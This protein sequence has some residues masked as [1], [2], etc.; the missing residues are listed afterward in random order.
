MKIGSN[1]EVPKGK[2]AAFGLNLSGR[3]SIFVDMKRVFSF[4]ALSVLLLPLPVMAQ[5]ETPVP[6]VTPPVNTA[7]IVAAREEAEERYKRMATDLQAVQSDN[8]ALHAKIAS[9]E[10]QI[11]NLRD[12]QAKPVDN[13]AVQDQLKLLAQKIEEVDK[14]R[15]EDK[16]TISDEIRKS[17]GK[18]Q[19]TLQDV[20]SL[21]TRESH[22][23]RD[24]HES[25]PKIASAVDSPAIENGYSYTI[26]S[27]DRLDL[28]VK[29]YNKDF[30][31][32]GL[33][34][35]TM[36]QAREANP[37]VNWNRL[38]VGQKIIIPR[39]DGG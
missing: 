8:E 15:L 6:T 26:A 35:I 34:P 17:V 36:K 25:R 22:D 3:D 4:I 39:P 38:L 23:S 21:P 32:K 12:A 20:P 28:I 33:K 24:T 37:N 16:D 30:R 1:G 2:V 27:G 14:K 19:S 13:S 7:A 10:Q 31:A 5:T 11:Q 9:L 18:L 29:A